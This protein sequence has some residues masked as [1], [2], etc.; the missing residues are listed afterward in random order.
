MTRVIFPAVSRSIS[1]AFFAETTSS[2]AVIQSKVFQALDLFC[3][4]APVDFVFF[5][6]HRQ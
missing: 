5:K 4:Y 3:K 2:P 1:T 6:S